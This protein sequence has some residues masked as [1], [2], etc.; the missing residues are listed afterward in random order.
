MFNPTPQFKVPLLVPAPV[1]TQTQT[2][3]APPAPDPS[4]ERQD[5]SR[6]I[7]VTAMFGDTVLDVRHLDSTTPSGK[8]SPLTWAL[9][10]AGWATFLAGAVLAV[11]GHYGLGTLLLLGGLGLGLS[12]NMRRRAE[13]GSPDYALGEASESNLHLRHEAIPASCFPLVEST[14]SGHVLNY[15][16]RMGGDITLG[17]NRVL[18]ADLVDTG[19]AQASNDYPGT[20]RCR[21]PATRGSRSTSARTP[22]WSTPLRR[23]AR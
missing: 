19:Q 10:G 3:P 16:P 1:Q 13:Q 15:T 2:T 7:E 14:A 17:P 23:R 21:S 11:T 20:Y 8:I 12:G 6:A 5:G 18:L 4:V 22:S 9:A